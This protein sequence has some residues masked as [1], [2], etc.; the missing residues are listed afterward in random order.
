[1]KRSIWEQFDDY[2]QKQNK[3]IY[4]NM[5][6]M[7]FLPPTAPCLVF[8]CETSTPYANRSKNVRLGLL[9][10]LG[11]LLYFTDDYIQLCAFKNSDLCEFVHTRC[12]DWIQSGRHGHWSV[13]N[14]LLHNKYLTNTTVENIL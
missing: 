13:I 6:N 14:I 8:A 10:L 4:F 1:M 2:K 7:D 3:V 12:K 9:Q 11:V 5:E